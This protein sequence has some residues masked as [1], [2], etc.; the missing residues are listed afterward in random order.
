MESP[1]GREGCFKSL[2]PDTPS[3]RGN[4]QL[5]KGVAGM[6][7]TLSAGVLEF[8]PVACAA[9]RRGARW[10]LNPQ[11]KKLG[12]HEPIKTNRVGNL[13]WVPTWLALDTGGVL[14]GNAL[15]Y[16]PK[17]RVF[18]RIRQRDVVGGLPFS[19]CRK[20][21]CFC[22]F[23]K[24]NRV[25][26]SGMGADLVGV[27]CGRDV[28]RGIL[29]LCAERAGVSADS[30]KGC[31]WRAVLFCVPNGRAFPRIHKMNRVG[32]PGGMPTRL[33]LDAGGILLEDCP[34]LRAEW[35]GVSAH[36]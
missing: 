22:G 30:S 1:A 7:G 13:R 15:F 17:G 36:S 23:I 26:R 4:G 35:A 8:L 33:A 16:A 29:L 12:F 5:N 14:L 18:P 3:L 6:K 32:N 20:G 19:A 9:L 25:R 31:C 24:M 10:R 21:G 28:V 34:F 27:G 11:G 2:V